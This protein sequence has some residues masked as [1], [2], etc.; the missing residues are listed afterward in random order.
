MTALV[1]PVELQLTPRSREVMEALAKVL[2]PDFVDDAAT[3]KNQTTA[4][5]SPPSIGQPW[6]GVDGIYVGISRGE[7][8]EPDGHLVLLNARADQRMEWDGAVQW[9]QGLGDGARLPTRFESA[10]I[11]ANARDYVDTSVWHWTGTQASSGGA[12][13]QNFISGSQDLSNVSAEAAVRAV[14]RFPL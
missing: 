3:G 6:P 14:R 1:I 5:A 8:S 2:R 11:Y 4:T 12:W 13:G 7:G 10:L 9:A